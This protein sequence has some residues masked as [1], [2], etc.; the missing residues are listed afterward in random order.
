MAEKCARI[1]VVGCGRSGTTLLQAMLSAHDEIISFPESQFFSNVID[2]YERRVMGADGEL[3]ISLLYLYQSLMMNMGIAPR[4]VSGINSIN[5]F[6]D[7][8]D[9]QNEKIKFNLNH[10]LLNNQIMK[11]VGLMDDEATREGKKAWLLKTP[12]NVSYIDII[13]RYVSDAKFVHIIRPGRDVVA[14]I[15]DAALKYPDTVWQ[16][17]F[18]KDSLE[19]LI[20]MWN[21]SVRQTIRYVSK[22]NHIAVSYE[23]LVENPAAELSRVFDFID[24]ADDPTCCTRYSSQTSN[25]VSSNEKWKSGVGNEVKKTDKYAELFDEGQKSELDSKLLDIDIAA[26]VES[27]MHV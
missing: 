19:R 18:Y 24:I 14:S 23:A 26:I 10:V 1:F 2:Q 6:I 15:Y 25:I 3:K 22:P 4:P 17:H 5:R 16:T 13:Q 11:M 12:S 20:N 21:E 9:I 8:S 7:K 27:S